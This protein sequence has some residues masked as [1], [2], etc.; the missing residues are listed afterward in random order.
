[1]TSLTCCLLAAATLMASPVMAANSAANACRAQS[2][3]HR[4]ALLELYTSEG[5]SSCPPADQY[6]AGLRAS[7]VTADQAVLLSE[8]VDYWNYIGWKD[9]YSRAAFTERQRWMSELANSRTIYTPEIFMSGKELRSWTSGGLPAAVQRINGLAA[10]A[11]ISIALGAAGAGGLPVEVKA[12][13]ARGGKLYVAL[14]QSG[15]ANQVTAGEN[16]GRLLRHDFV[17][18]EWLEPVAL[19]GGKDGAKNSAGVART[20]TLPAGAA[21]GNLGV[22]AFVQSE[23]GEVL[24]ALALP[25]CG[26]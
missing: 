23:Q 4:V 11:D 8:H 20:F 6:V 15:L 21:N 7:G 12:S 25:V 1:M 3:A 18:R 9:P 13:S 5:C 14:V 26:G 16:R 17:V 22:S 10:Q 24:Q 2:P 19:A